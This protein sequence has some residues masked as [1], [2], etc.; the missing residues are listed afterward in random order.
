MGGGSSNVFRKSALASGLLTA[1]EL[2]AGV[3]ELCAKHGLAAAEVNDELL[4]AKLVENG[5]VN[6]WQAGQL[7][8][9]RSKFNLGPYQIV[10]SIGEGGMGQVFKAEHTVM[11]RIVAV[12]VLP[13]YKSTPESEKSFMREIR[14]QA[15]LD[16]HHLVRAYDAGH[17]GNVNY[18]V[19]EFVNGIDLRRFIRR[20]GRLSMTA[21][22]SVISQAAMGLEHAHSRG[23]IHRDVKPGNLLVSQDGVVKVSDLGLA[24]SF[25]LEGEAQN[26]G[27]KIV[28][29]ADYLAPEQ[30]TA[31]QLLGPPTDVYSL[32]CTLY[33]AVTGKVPF[34]G[35]TAATKV[36]AHCTTEPLDPRRLNPELDDDFVDLI[37]A[38]MMKQPPERIQTMGEVV[39]R[40]SKWADQQSIAHAA[41]VDHLDAIAVQSIHPSERRRTPPVLSDTEPNFLVE[42]G[43]ES[44]PVESPSQAGVN[45]KP[46][47]GLQ[48]ET[49]PDYVSRYDQALLQGLNEAKKHDHS[50]AVAV[51]VFLAILAIC[52]SIAIW[53][54]T[55]G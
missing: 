15:Q 5:Q 43:Q 41:A 49:V 52:A 37:A 55:R 26:L 12:K 4:A 30:I 22:A 29:T 25:N 21:A 35:G 16:H 42:P 20:H 38:M 18:L 36:R 2:D 19:T 17:D 34:P 11:G 40:L 9:G 27:D 45:T 53:L 39:R 50:F 28:G 8:A 51:I 3:A 44:G 7:A 31:P 32:G 23:L 6:R 14:N 1:E 13:R 48:E 10:D 24:G 46:V 54:V 47:Y 33:Y